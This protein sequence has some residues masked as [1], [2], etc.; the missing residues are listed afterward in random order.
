MP[1]YFVLH[2]FSSMVAYKNVS[3]FLLVGSN[4]LGL[5]G[6]LPLRDLQSNQPQKYNMPIGNSIE[7]S[8]KM[9][10][11]PMTPMIPPFSESKYGIINPIGITAG[12][13][14]IYKKLTNEAD[15]QI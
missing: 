11:I 2:H 4:K 6:A 3:V 9:K 12:I 13:R 8:A 1:E 15:V 14:I 5:T 7:I 10:M